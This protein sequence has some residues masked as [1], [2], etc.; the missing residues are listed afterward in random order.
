M[1]NYHTKLDCKT[2]GN[3]I[4]SIE[5]FSNNHKDIKGKKQYAYESN[6]ELK[7]RKVCS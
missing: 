6:E 4:F 1:F 5:I 7:L 3:Q 2:T